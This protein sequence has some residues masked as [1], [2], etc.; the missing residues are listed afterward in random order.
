M[1][2]A[3]FP[4]VGVGIYRSARVGGYDDPCGKG[5]VEDIRMNSCLA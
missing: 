1:A 3:G 5:L 2:G 4:T